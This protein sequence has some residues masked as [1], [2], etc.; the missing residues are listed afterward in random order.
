[1]RNG[2][3]RGK[4]WQSVTVL[5]FTFSLFIF[6][7]SCTNPFEPPRQK[8]PDAG[9]GSFSLSVDGVRAG[10]TILPVTVLDADDFEAYTLEFFAEG[11]TTEPVVTEERTN[12]DLGDPVTLEVGT[13]DLIVTAYIMDEEME[14]PLARGILEG[15]VIGPGEAV[16]R[17]VTLEAIIDDGEGTFS[18]DISYPTVTEA[19]MTITPLDDQTGTPEQTLSFTGATPDVETEGSV[20]LNAGYYRVVFNLRNA[21]GQ[22]AVH[23]EILHIYQN[24]DSAF[25]FTFEESHFV[26]FITVTN[27][28]NADAGSLRQ[29]ISDIP[30]GGT[31]IFDNSV[32]TIT[33]TARLTIDKS[34]TIEGNGVIITRD[35]SWTTV[36]AN[37]QLLYISGATTTVSISR[38]HFKDGRA[39]GNAGAINNGGNLTLESCIFSG[40]QNNSYGGAIYNTGTMSVKGCTFYGNSTGQYGGAIGNV[41]GTLTLEGNLFYGNT[42]SLSL[43]VVLNNNGTVTSLGYNVVDKTVATGDTNSGFDAASNG[44]DKGDVSVIPVTPVSFKLLS[45][46][47]ALNVIDSLP[48]DYP[49]VDFYGKAITAPA[50]AGAVQSTVSGTGYYLD[51]SVNNS[52]RGTAAITSGAPGDEGLY[53]GEV[54]I[55]AT[56]T[57][58]GIFAYW[59]V[60]GVRDD[61]GN[62]LVFNPI[63]THAAVQAVFTEVFEV[64]DFTDSLSGNGDA[65]TLRLALYNA[66]DGDIIRFDPATDTVKLKRVLPQITKSITI[67]GKGVTI[68]IDPDVTWTQ[69][70]TS[71]L[72]RISGASATVS[73]SRVWFK[74]GKTTGSGGAIDNN[75]ATLS[76][77]SCIFSGN[78]TSFFGG[79]VNNTGTMSV[80]GCTFYGNN[81]TDQR[82]GAI[83]MS[84]GTLTLEGN[85][86]YGNTGANGYPAVG[87][88]TGVTVTSL[89][90]N[91]VDAVLGNSATT[92]S[93]FA[94]AGNGTDKGSINVLPVSPV[95]F[96]LLS[97]SDAAEAITSLPEGYPTLDFYGDSIGNGAAAGAVQAAVSGTGYAL[98]VSV[99]NNAAGSI[100]NITPKPDADGLISG[101][102]EITATENTGYGL[103]Y[104]L[105]NGVQNNSPSPL[106]LNID[107]H[108]TVQA[109]FGQVI[110]VTVFTSDST[111][112]NG[113]TGTLRLALYNAQ[114]N[115][116]IRFTGV[117]AGTSAVQLVRALPDITKSI[118]IEGNG[119]T[120]T[121]AASWTQENGSLLT[122]NNASATVSISRIH[123]KGGRYNNG[124]AINKINGT[125]S[126]ESCIFSDNKVTTTGRGGA[127]YNNDG[128][129]NVKGCTF[130]GN[131]SVYQGGAIG[132]YNGTLTLEGNLFYGNTATSYP[133]V[134][135]YSGTE[136]SRGYN[137][138]DVALGTTST[139]SGFASSTINPNTDKGS[140]NVLPVSPVSFRLLSGSPALNVIAALPEGYP[141]VDF[142]G[143]SIANGAAAG[144]VQQAVTGTGYTLVTS[145]NNS[146]AG[147]I[148]SVSPAPDADG[149]I[150]GAVTITATA[151]APYSLLY[152]LVNGVQNNSPS[153][154]SLNIDTHTTVQAVFGRVIEVTVFTSDSTSGNGNTGTLRLALN[155]AGDNDI[156]RFTGVT[157]GTSTV[158]LVRALDI[159]KSITIEGNGIT[160]TKASS[161]AAGTDSQLLSI[162]AGTV[163]TISRVHFKGG[164]M[165]SN[166]GAAVR[167]NGGNVSLESCIFSDNQTS[168]ASSTGGAVFNTNS[169]TMSVK[170]CTF[171]GN[172]SAYRGGAI[173]M[174]GATLT[175]EGNLFYGNTALSAANG[176]VVYQNSGTVTSLGYNVVDVTLGAA[177]TASG[178]NAADNG[179]DKTVEDLLTANTD[180]PFTDATNGD[181][182]PVSGIQ[183]VMPAAAI[184]GFPATDFFDD[185]RTWPGAPGAVNGQ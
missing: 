64:T 184:E 101:A 3:K 127:I 13:Y 91:V 45:G 128:I 180:S 176:N 148:D 18:W 165:T 95:S 118:T 30:A 59:L 158:Q 126:L 71:Q 92:Q 146:A 103:L 150:S 15:I 157:A 132:N 28:N 21:G 7:L 44:T 124:A 140:I 185:P 179:T 153:P 108:T 10:R 123:F 87:I 74:D 173:Y 94:A 138:V 160:I 167:N 171:Y 33:L 182:S 29:A 135:R 97:D 85:L 100:D 107:T 144:A 73:I 40:N 41:T 16:E 136:T 117:T 32:T 43:P 133:V 156:I 76:L 79:A 145:V 82:G 34:L 26:N 72:L 129:M 93:G 168:A 130:Y 177:N 98:V 110:E 6:H 181:F 55:T 111:S 143:N 53:S 88:Q 120:I 178:F 60:N 121:K 122:I 137:V 68:T 11:T 159:T 77:E 67:E 27:G 58:R 80:K 104:W 31:I 125:L 36:N 20:T 141:T 105:V 47:A 62:L 54:T 69:S 57:T 78:Q 163:V 39:S 38:V 175:L 83:Y 56:P 102:V 42:A 134:S 114:D 113:N 154:L 25:S 161:F 51:V 50:A 152:W 106:S 172:I 139:Q 174:N 166:G 65:G 86:F 8:N 115:D 119:I 1:M 61:S 35:S 48:A 183:N 52:V 9:K 162:N 14:K 90:Y 2:G 24:M 66:Q 70:T 96:R 89:G 149:L 169:G 131:S 19:S 63:T 170:G 23:R 151:T 49:T 5:I 109:V 147:R 142:Y 22:Y 84:G 4:L 12:D 116:I 164:R 46:S 75:N 81:S 37:S 99:N 155:N 17:S 112:G